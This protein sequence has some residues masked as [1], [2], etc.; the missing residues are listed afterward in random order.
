MMLKSIPFRLT[1]P[2]RTS[3]GGLDFSLRSPEFYGSIHFKIRKRI[4]LLTVL[5]C[6]AASLTVVTTM[7]HEEQQTIDNLIVKQ[8][9][10]IIKTS[11]KSI[12]TSIL[13]ECLSHLN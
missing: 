3:N 6:E 13:R 7:C 1:V 12:F 11:D 5:N 8:N 2:N 9:C 4:G 10:F